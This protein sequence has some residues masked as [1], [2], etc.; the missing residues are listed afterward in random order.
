MMPS[1]L[2]QS[3]KIGQQVSVGGYTSLSNVVSRRSLNNN[4]EIVE[5]EDITTRKVHLPQIPERCG[6]P[7]ISLSLLLDFAI[8]NTVHELTILSELLPKKKETDRKISV[9]EFSHITRMVFVKLLAIV[10]WLKISKKFE[11]LASIRYFLDE[12]SQIFV[13][14]ADRL[15]SIIREELRFAR[16][17]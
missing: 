2:P 9:V 14:T 16:F 15:V 8:Q 11:S 7:T 6:P 13:E 4:N 17:D 3:D 10:K 5:E 1:Q 12:Q